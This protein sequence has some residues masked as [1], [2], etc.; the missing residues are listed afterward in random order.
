MV[1]QQLMMMQLHCSAQLFK[2]K[3]CSF[4][5]QMAS[6]MYAGRTTSNLDWD[7]NAWL[8]SCLQQSACFWHSTFQRRFCRGDRSVLGVDLF[9]PVLLFSETLFLVGSGSARVCFG[10]GQRAV[11]FLPLLP[12]CVKSLYTDVLQKSMRPCGSVV[13]QCF[14]NEALSWPGLNILRV[15]ISP[16]FCWFTGP[17]WFRKWQS[18]KSIFP[19]LPQNFSH[20][21]NLSLFL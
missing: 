10:G 13:L 12:H 6:S 7:F 8:I 18:H 2:E 20:R 9:S 15:L 16:L 4:R 5:D 14:L 19:F 3:H 1:L 17:V 21:R 11:A